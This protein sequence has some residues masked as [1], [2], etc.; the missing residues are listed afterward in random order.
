MSAAEGEKRKTLN[1]RLVG[2]MVMRLCDDR[3]RF[4]CS[5]ASRRAVGCG[6]VGV[7]GG[8]ADQGRAGQGKAGQDRAGPSFVERE[9]WWTTGV[10]AQD[11]AQVI[12]VRYG[13]MRVCGYPGRASVS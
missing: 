3:G 11:M 9:I 5:R 13:G 12:V 2:V 6:G 7:G 10:L 4:I 1:G 8:G